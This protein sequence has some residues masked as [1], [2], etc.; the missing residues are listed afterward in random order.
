MNIKMK[1]V[2]INAMALSLMM[3]SSTCEAQNSV[4]KDAIKMTDNEQFEKAAAVYKS[5]ITKDPLNA[6]I[7]FYLG[8]NVFAAEKTDSAL[9][10]FKKGIEV[11]SKYP[12]NHIGLAKVLRA[13]GKAS[14]AQTSLDAAFALFNEK[15]VKI[16]DE[17]KVRTYVE[18]AQALLEGIPASPD[19]ALDYIGKALSMDEANVEAYIVKGDALFVKDELNATDPLNAYKK[20]A[21][22]DQ[23]SAKTVA[24][25]GYM[26]YRAKQWQ[27]SYDKYNE[28]LKIDANFAPAY[29]GRGDASYYLNKLEEGLKDY[30]K[31]LELN[32][33]NISARKRYAGFLFV[34]KK[35]DE[36]LTEIMA[37]EKT[38][39][40]DDLMLNRL[41]GYVLYEKGDYTN[42][43]KAM[44]FY[45]KNQS[46]DKISATDYEYMGRIQW[47]LG[48]D[49]ERDKYLEKAIDLD[50]KNKITIATEIIGGYKEKKDNLNQIKWYR[51]KTKKWGSKDVNDYYYMGLCGYNIDSCKIVV[52]SFSEYIKTMPD[53]ALAYY[54]IAWGTDCM[55][56]DEPKKWAAKEWYEKFVSKVKPEETE[57]MAKKISE[58]YFYFARYHYFAATPDYA[59]SKCYAT[60]VATMNASETWV[61][62][63]NDFMLYKEIKAATAAGECK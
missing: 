45:M 49:A 57:K 22:L 54:Y 48:N 44:E 30:Q 21:E 11:N 13:K 38:I 25:M 61:K 53:Y 34:A 32:K 17:L 31:Y 4:L 37:I 9:M 6:E 14:E 62:A 56:K 3:M 52:E 20:A 46:A 58:A 60:K 1:I 10:V 51:L 27:K 16:K 43:L 39:G 15:G 63:A 36:C 41:K 42:A 50:P 24:R 35:F 5:V 26:Y 8:E 2:S 23:T 47:K 33:G 18:A 7:Y 12:L 19:K 40:T 59:M 55:D 28:A 29:S